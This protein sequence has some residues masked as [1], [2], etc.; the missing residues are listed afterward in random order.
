M[1]AAKMGRPTSSPK[2]TM[3]RVRMDKETL[4][5]LDQCVEIKKSNRSQIIR[6]AITLMSS[7]IKK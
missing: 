4:S 1:S 5:K 7:Q 2:N 6:D 3:I